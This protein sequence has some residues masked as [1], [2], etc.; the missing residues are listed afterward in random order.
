MYATL[1]RVTITD[2]DSGLRELRER[3][4]PGVSGQPGFVSGYWT[5]KGNSGVSLVVWESEEAANAAS[6]GIRSVVPEGV[7]LDDVE[8]REVVANA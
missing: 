8:V 7:T 6:E 3:V 1:V 4:V 5:R 2:E